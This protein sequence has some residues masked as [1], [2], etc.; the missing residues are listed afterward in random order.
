MK[1]TA[2]GFLPAIIRIRIV[3]PTLARASALR[4]MLVTLGHAVVEGDGEADVVLADHVAPPDKLPAVV[5]GAGAGEY[6]G[7]L[8]EGASGEQIDAALRAVAAGLRVEPMVAEVRAFGAA[9]ETQGA[10]LLTARETDVLKAV[11][12][13]L[14]NKEIARELDISLHTVKFHLESVMRKLGASSRTKAVTSAM[15]LGLLEVFRV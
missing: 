11:S 12:L 8:A 1:A 6:E 10:I 2:A 3:A 9:D 5:I 14:S 13:G 7:R 15:R 4:R